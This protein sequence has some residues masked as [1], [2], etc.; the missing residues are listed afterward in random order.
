MATSAQSDSVLELYSAYFHR[1]ADATGFAF[2]QKSFDT[3]FAAATGKNDAAKSAEALQKIAVD[4]STS[5]EYK[6][7]YPSILSNEEFVRKI[8]SNLLSRPDP[9]AE[10]VAFWTGHVDK[11]T[12]T[13][14][15]AINKII[16]GAKANTTPQGKIDAA[17][18]AN[19]NVISKY[20]AETL[21]SN[22]VD[23]AKKAFADVTAD[24]DSIAKAKA[25]LKDVDSIQLTDKDDTL[26]GTAAD[27][28]FNSAQGTLQSDDVILDTSSADQDTLNIAMLI[29]DDTIAPLVANIETINV[30]SI[31]NLVGLNA[32]NIK[33]TTTL[34]LTTTTTSGSADVTNVASDKVGSITVGDS[35]TTLNV[36]TDSNKGTGSTALEITANKATTVTL[37]GAGKANS[38]VLKSAGA[39]TTIN[40]TGTTGNNSVVIEDGITA[41]S[42][43]F[44][45][46][47]GSDKLVISGQS[48]AASIS[49]TGGDGENTFVV[50]TTDKALTAL[51][52]NGGAGK[53][54]ATIN[55]KGTIDKSSASFSTDG[56]IDELI[57][58]ATS[59]ASVFKL[60]NANKLAATNGKI[61]LLGDQA[62]TFMGDSAAFDGVQVVDANSVGAT[63]K[64]TNLGAV[65]DFSRAAFKSI[66]IAK[67]SNSATVT[68]NKDSQVKLS[69]EAADALVIKGVDNGSMTADLANAKLGSVKFESTGTT[70][71]TLNLTNTTGNST[72]SKLDLSAVK[73]TV[74]TGDKALTIS[75]YSST[76]DNKL[77]ASA[78]TGSLIIKGANAVTAGE[79][80]GG[81]GTDILVI[82]AANSTD[83]AKINGGVGSDSLTTTNISGVMT[84]GAGS[85]S[86]VIK[87][88]NN[89]TSSSTTTTKISDF[90]VAA[91]KLQIL[92]NGKESSF[93]NLIAGNGDEVKGNTNFFVKTVSK[94]NTTLG[95]SDAV[96]VLKGSY[97]DNDA[98]EAKL[99][100]NV[101]LTN[102]IGDDLMVAWNNISG[103]AVI[104][105]VNFT[106]A[107]TNALADNGQATD[108]ITLS[109][110]SADSLSVQNF[111]FV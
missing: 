62:V 79:V 111:D 66:N 43:S 68:L 58:N 97:A 14:E 10:G 51:T 90:T 100:L 76:A 45:G 52:I 110:V 102:D 75:D 73:T 28:T 108:L 24:P 22:N 105:S 107:H 16:E 92:L 95:S 78:S 30:N 65:A 33:N 77:D 85:D 67:A 42:L 101:K 29:A 64:V 84:G 44:T 13:K 8:Y 39:D 93:D 48:S 82:N 7:F 71:D 38:F 36:Q 50:N 11:G 69:A 47:A 31:S 53:D 20:F 83:N 46:G 72:F 54:K 25:S 87:T 26:T 103:D 19:K 56:N 80:I 98:M 55:L 4:M 2:W 18:I 70:L 60:A 91:D 12:I 37:T 57:F 41:K 3:F 5:T 35:I 1:A 17:L 109:G 6:E 86:F 81:A 23:A 99:A 61:V 59:S 104:S 96:V 27:D 34:N 40:I 106:T 89:A 32:N 94:A 88:G 15:Q 49:L 9:D 63:L 74:V 21:K